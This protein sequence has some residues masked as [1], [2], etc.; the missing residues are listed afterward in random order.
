MGLSQLACFAGI[1]INHVPY[2]STISLD[3]LCILQSTLS[4]RDR[5]ERK[6]VVVRE[7]KAGLLGKVSETEQISEAGRGE[8]SLWTTTCKGGCQW[9]STCSES[10]QSLT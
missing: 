8:G 1:F 3:E 9:P 2:S 5:R 10:L 4:G 6:Q 7:R